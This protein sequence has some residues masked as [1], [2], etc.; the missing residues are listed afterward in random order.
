LVPLDTQHTRIVYHATLKP[1]VAPPPLIGVPLMR[2][3][4][5]TQ[6]DALVAEVQAR[7]APLN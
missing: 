5:R 4:I 6:F 1:R 3:A 2:S 7:G